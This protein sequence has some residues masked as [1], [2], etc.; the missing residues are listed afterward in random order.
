[1]PWWIWA[2]IGYA[3]AASIGSAL[4][5]WAAGRV[6]AWHEDAYDSMVDV[7]SDPELDRP[8]CDC[9]DCED[10]RDLQVEEA[11]LRAQMDYS[12]YRFGYRLPGERDVAA[13]QAAELNQEKQR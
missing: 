5:F 3:V 12:S 10:E 8:D 7:V 13:R 11:V 6:G 9:E 4:A 1:M 2:G